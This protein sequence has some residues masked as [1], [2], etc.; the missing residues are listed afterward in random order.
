MAWKNGPDSFHKLIV[1]FVDGNVRTLYSLDWRH[2]SSKIRDEKIG[3]ERFYKKIAEW[4]ARA[5][6]VE[7]YV[8]IYGTKGGRKV[9]RFENGMQVALKNQY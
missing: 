8:N 6:V 7:I 5:G 4:G 9:A 2:S 3:F 1:W